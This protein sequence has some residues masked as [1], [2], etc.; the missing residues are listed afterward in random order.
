MAESVHLDLT[1]VQLDF[2]PL[3]PGTYL[4]RVSSCE[5]GNSK[6]S[7]NPVVNWQFDVEDEPYEGRKLFY[8]TSLM[9]KAIWKF[10][11]TMVALGWT[12][13]EL[14]TEDGFE[15]EADDMLDLMC[16]VVVTQE[17]YEG[18]IRNRV[19]NVLPESEPS[20]ADLADAAD[21]EVFEIG[22]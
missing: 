11:G 21:D 3:D 10:A 20:P 8:H 22:D 5:V 6:S 15:F 12:E 17:P 1:G 7:G 14:K 9:P 4:A 2:E 13:D 19:N 18:K 16:R